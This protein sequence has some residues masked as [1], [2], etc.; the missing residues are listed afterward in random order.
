MRNQ[1]D[2]STIL[3]SQNHATYLQN[4]NEG[5][6]RL[7]GI[8]KE[9]IMGNASQMEEVEPADDGGKCRNT[10]KNKG[11]GCLR[12]RPSSYE[13]TSVHVEVED[14]MVE[15]QKCWGIR[16]NTANVSR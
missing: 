4:K 2:E 3:G 11:L 15:K 6:R 13:S 16:V 8:R 1:D 9:V 5:G 10:L 14:D 12:R 7:G